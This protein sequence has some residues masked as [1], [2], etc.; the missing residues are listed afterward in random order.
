MAWIWIT[1]KDIFSIILDHVYISQYLFRDCQTLS[2]NWKNIFDLRLRRILILILVKR[3]WCLSHR[4]NVLNSIILKNNT[5]DYKLASVFV[6]EKKGIIL[7]ILDILKINKIV[8]WCTGFKRYIGNCWSF[9]FD[10]SANTLLRHFIDH[11][12]RRIY[13]THIRKSHIFY[14]ESLQIIQ[15][16]NNCSLRQF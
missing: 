13:S 6:V 14:L 12:E 9:Y 4:P 5:F 2:L 11:N 15:S 7:E 3:V 10:I 16:M 1:F 8:W